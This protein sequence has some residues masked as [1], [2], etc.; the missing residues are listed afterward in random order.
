MLIEL[1]YLGVLLGVGRGSNVTARGGAGRPQSY[2]L[3]TR[4]ATAVSK[5]GAGGTPFKCVTNFFKIDRRPG[6]TL[7]QY[8]VD[9]SPEEDETKLRK[10]LL[11][12][13]RP[14]ISNGN[15]LFD[16]TMLFCITRYEQPLKLTVQV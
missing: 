1:I 9:F 6:W 16:G 4:P 14:S 10:E 15:F 5:Q 3:N 7:L 12:Q 13:H 11:N 2:I 8:R